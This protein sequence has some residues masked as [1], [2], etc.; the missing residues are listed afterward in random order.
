[1]PILSL[2]NKQR[3]WAFFMIH[4][5]FGRLF[6]SIG[7]ALLL[8]VGY[9]FWQFG[10][11]CGQLRE[12]VFRLHVL[13]ASDSEED[14]A[15]KYLVRDAIVEKTGDLFATANSA[16]DAKAIAEDSLAELEAIATQTLHDHG[17]DDSVHAE[18]THMYF[19]TRDYENFSLPAGEYDALR[20]VIGEGKGHNWWCVLYPSL[21]LPC[22]VPEEELEALS[23]EEADVISNPDD[24]RLRF[25]AVDL[26]ESIRHHFAS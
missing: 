22:A 17:S 4:H 10:Q 26:W 24:Y 12:D 8:S 14:Q 18:V 1:M 7:L 21:C 11:D 9:S 23:E 20:I 19:T 6:V 15:L 2:Q 5:L 13:A 3:K 16:A 25:A